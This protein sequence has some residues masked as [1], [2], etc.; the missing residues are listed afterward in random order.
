MT[1]RTCWV[2]PACKT[3]SEYFAATC[4]E[5]DLIRPEESEVEDE[6]SD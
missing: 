2:C 5:C 6:P 4:G 3:L 1:D